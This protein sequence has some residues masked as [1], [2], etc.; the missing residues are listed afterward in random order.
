LP[1]TNKT[2]SVADLHYR[3]RLEALKSVDQHVGELVQKLEGLGQLDDTVI[4]YTS[5]NGFQ[6]GQHRLPGDKRHLYEH[7]IRVPFCIRGPTITPNTTSVQIVAN[8]DIAPTIVDIV[9]QQTSAAKDMMDG[10]SFWKYVQ[11]RPDESFTK[12]H[13]LLVTYHG[14]GHTPCGMLE[15]PPS[16]DQ[17]DSFNNTYYCVR[18]LLMGEENSM[19]CRF[20]DDEHFVEFYDLVKNPYQLNND[21]ADLEVWQRQRYERR[22]QELMKC[23]G[24]TCRGQ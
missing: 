5:D 22:L 2:A 6:F 10:T 19:Y 7:D 24:P 9:Q 3:R 17:I 14:E 23:Q 4:M 8:I 13:D 15:C 12:R 18:T 20:E 16:L 11:D 1:L 21:Y